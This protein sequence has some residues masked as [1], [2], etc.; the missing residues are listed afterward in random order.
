MRDTWR[1]I[2]E[3]LNKKKSQ[4]VYIS[5]IVHNGKQFD[6]KIDIANQLNKF[7]T[8]IGQTLAKKCGKNSKIVQGLDENYVFQ[9]TEPF[10]DFSIQSSRRI[11][12]TQLC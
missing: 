3:I 2:N 9:Q 7:F 12:W 8:N 4:P 5:N 11:I 10:L 6:K 1:I